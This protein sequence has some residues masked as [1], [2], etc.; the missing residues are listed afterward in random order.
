[1]QRQT[2]RPLWGP[3]RRLF[4]P[5]FTSFGRSCSLQLDALALRDVLCAT[6][7]VSCIG[8][9][10]VPMVG[11][12]EVAERMSRTRDGHLQDRAFSSDLSLFMRK[13]CMRSVYIL[14]INAEGYNVL[15]Y[16]FWKLVYTTQCLGWVCSSAH[17]V[18]FARFLDLSVLS[19]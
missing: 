5:I 18:S 15:Y 3:T 6:I 8:V 7:L 14:L 1:M 19:L 2:T 9:K 10:N 13:L 17:K 16:S 12:Q 11:R 4:N